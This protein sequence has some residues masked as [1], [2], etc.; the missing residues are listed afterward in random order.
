MSGP[1][2]EPDAHEGHYRFPPARAYAL[3]RCL[4]AIKSDPAFRARYLADPEA[5][6][7][8]AGLD[9][10][11]RAAL[12]ANDRDRLVARGAHAYLVFMADL[13]LRMERGG[14]RFEYF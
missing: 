8:G 1:A 12:L 2:A 10:E 13:R 5:V 7:R 14:S 9:D 3:N 6:A 4:Y 11:D